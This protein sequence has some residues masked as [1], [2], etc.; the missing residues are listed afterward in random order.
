MQIF[1][2]FFYRGKYRGVIK[3]KQGR[4]KNLVVACMLICG[5]GFAQNISQPKF[6]VGATLSITKTN[7]RFENT[8]YTNQHLFLYQNRMQGGCAVFADVSLGKR[9]ELGGEISFKDLGWNRKDTMKTIE[10][11]SGLQTRYRYHYIGLSVSSGYRFFA[12]KIWSVYGTAGCGIAFLV[13]SSSKTTDNGNI[14]LNQAPL[15]NPRKQLVNIMFG[16][17]N[18]FQLRP[19]WGIGL[20]ISGVQYLSKTEPAVTIRTGMTCVVSLSSYFIFS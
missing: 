5:W 14:Y 8:D 18:N 12:N 17:K 6:K 13:H 7:Y 16:V 1:I 4:A 19:R 20:T 15:L 2:L 11:P 3:V 9:I 10:H